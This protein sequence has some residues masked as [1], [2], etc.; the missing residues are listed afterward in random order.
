MAQQRNLNISQSAA[1][2]STAQH[3]T[4]PLST[5]NERKEER[6]I[7]EQLW[8]LVRMWKARKA[9]GN[10]FIVMLVGAYYDVASVI[11]LEWSAV[12]C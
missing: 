3:S 12:V 5:T 9:T 8:K 6:N 11:E 1:Q 10:W 4:A 7:A 2:H